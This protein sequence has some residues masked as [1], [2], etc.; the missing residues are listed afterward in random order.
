MSLTKEYLQQLAY[1]L[2]SYG[3]VPV[4]MKGKVPIGKNWQNLRNDP[5]VD[6]KDISEGRYPTRVRQIGHLYDAG[7][8]NNVGVLTGAPSG[9]VVLD[10][11][12]KDNGLEKWQGLVRANIVMTGLSMPKTFMVKSGEGGFHLYFRYHDGLAK[13]PNRNRILDLPIDFRT[14]GGIIVAPGSV[15][16]V[17]NEYYQIVDGY[18]NNQPILAEMPSWLLDLLVA[19]LLYREGIKNPTLEQFAA[20]NI[21]L[22]FV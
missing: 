12:N 8:V 6:Q 11:D 18:E 17:T 15:S 3:W 14:N 16:Y 4:G 13:M 22:G 9:I 20:K 21:E 19:D 2:W 10:I 7:L 5:I 1:S